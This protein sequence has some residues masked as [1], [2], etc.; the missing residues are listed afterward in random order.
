MSAKIIAVC[1]QKG[2][3][4][5]TTT[6]VNLGVGLVDEGKRVL[7]IDADPQGSLSISLGIG[8]A[9][10]QSNTLSTVMMHEMNREQYD[11]RSCIR[12][13]DEGVDYLPANIELASVDVA[14]INTMSREYILSGVIA[15]VREEYDV[16][17]IDC[18]PS[19]GMLTVNALAAADSVLIPVE[20]K[21][22]PIK[23]LQQLFQTIGN[24]RYRINQDLEIEGILFT[25]CNRT[26]L[27]DQIAKA[28][29]NA[30]G[31]N[32]RIFE[33]MIPTGTNA[34]HRISSMKSGA[35]DIISVAQTTASKNYTY[36]ELSCKAGEEIL[37]I[38]GEM[39]CVSSDWKDCI[40]NGL[41]NIP[42]I[43]EKEICTVFR[44]KGTTEEDEQALT[45][46]LSEAFPFMEVSVIDG[47]QPVYRWLMGV[48]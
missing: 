26:N 28:V 25:M 46:A 24:I 1:N 18:M 6:T 15:Q 10:A 36:H 38:N 29:K 43:D 32:I 42:D 8:D 22:L 47:G 35:E 39:L 13:H 3:V 19:L 30:Y 48:S 9:D 45:D 12:H 11:V 7:L 14:M 27:S 21:F 4:G 41:K 31:E 17:L 40:I 16:I 5:K 34:A 2:G 33:T 44:G 37:F 23:G 20:T